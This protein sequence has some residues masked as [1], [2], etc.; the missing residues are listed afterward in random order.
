MELLEYKS[1]V[2]YMKFK[3]I[4][5][6]YFTEEQAID[7]L[8]FNNYYFK[9]SNY[10]DNFNLNLMTYQNED[11]NRYTNLDFFHLVD[12]SRI[13]MQ[14]RYLI[15]KMCL[16]IEHALKV[17]TMREVTDDINEDGIT[18]IDE[19]VQ[20]YNNLPNIPR[21]YNNAIDMISY[22]SSDRYLRNQYRQ[23]SDNTPLWFFIE[24][25][26]FGHLSS[27]IEFLNNHNSGKNYATF[28]S[29]SKEIKYVKNI[30]NK[31]A[32]NAP[33]LN[34]I[35]LTNQIPAGRWDLKIYNYARR[36]DLNSNQLSRRLTNHNIHDLTAM[37][38]VFDKVILKEE[39]KERRKEELLYLIERCKENRHIYDENLKSVFRYFDLMVDKF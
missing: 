5:F 31:A 29:I 25:V 19:F 11:I 35:S 4:K 14:L 10:K 18:I 21:R 30:R 13:D 20:Y 39:R 9:L 26:Q 15:L 17:W 36:S 2:F 34:T 37:L 1:L 8:K 12:L 16:D 22:I 6:E 23:Y 28:N 38:Y 27:F 7:F 24:H 3:G 33:I 32:H